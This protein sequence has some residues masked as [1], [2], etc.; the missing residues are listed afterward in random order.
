MLKKCDMH[1]AVIGVLPLYW[2]RRFYVQPGQIGVFEMVG[3]SIIKIELV[4]DEQ[5]ARNVAA[6][7]VEVYRCEKI[8]DYFVKEA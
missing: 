6:H 1:V 2:I 7:M 8:I 5:Q 3:D 4:D